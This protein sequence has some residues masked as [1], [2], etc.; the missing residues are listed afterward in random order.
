L[1]DFADINV[2]LNANCEKSPEGDYVAF[3]KIQMGAA[4]YETVI[5]YDSKN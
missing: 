2:V 1:N 5:L 4:P 3:Q